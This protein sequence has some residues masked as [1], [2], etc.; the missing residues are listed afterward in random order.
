MFFV[1]LSIFSFWDSKYI[2]DNLILSHR[3]LRLHSLF[4]YQFYF[5]VLIWI[6]VT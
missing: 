4:L 2:S 6:I 1:P 5:S 3:L